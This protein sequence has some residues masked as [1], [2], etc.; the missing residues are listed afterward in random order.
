[1]KLC[2]ALDAYFSRSTEPTVEGI[3]PLLGN[4]T[5]WDETRLRKLTDRYIVNGAF[6]GNK[7]YEDIEKELKKDALDG[8]DSLIEIRKKVEAIGPGHRRTLESIADHI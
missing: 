6:K 4:S 2:D 1:M 7:F 3:L 8:G 5:G